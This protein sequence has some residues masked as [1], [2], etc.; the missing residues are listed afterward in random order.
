MLTVGRAAVTGIDALR[1]LQFYSR[2][3]SRA[4]AG[5]HGTMSDSPGST[6]ACGIPVRSS[7]TR[8]TS[9]QLKETHEELAA[10]QGDGRSGRR[11]LGFA[12]SVVGVLCSAG[13][14]DDDTARAALAVVDFTAGN[15]LEEQAA[16]QARNAAP[17]APERLRQA[18]VE[19]NFPHLG[20][21]TSSS[22]PQ[23][24][25]LWSSGSAHV[26]PDRSWELS[27]TVP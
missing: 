1:L 24:P 22:A 19:G 10:E 18:V 11:P 26:C 21:A 20:A 4:S 2:P 17:A 7:R 3:A 14:T 13:F 9:W 12:D 15:T 6:A 23:S 27:R 5:V 16:G 25:Q 8:S